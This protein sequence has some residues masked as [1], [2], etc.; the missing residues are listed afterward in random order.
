MKF[1]LYTKSDCPYCQMAMTLL[2]EHKKD[3]ECDALRHLTMSFC[4]WVLV[5]K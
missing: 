5:P 4:V 3:F 2:A 1:R